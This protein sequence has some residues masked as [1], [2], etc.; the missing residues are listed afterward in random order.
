M[1]SHP[2]MEGKHQIKANEEGNKNRVLEYMEVGGNHRE[3]K[4][5]TGAPHNHRQ[6]S[7]LPRSLA[8]PVSLACA[9]EHEVDPT[10]ATIPANEEG[11]KNRLRLCGCDPIRPSEKW[12]PK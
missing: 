2:C 8:C 3:N 5:N 11:N 1:K 6:F 9:R 12:R 7:F 10:T 4:G